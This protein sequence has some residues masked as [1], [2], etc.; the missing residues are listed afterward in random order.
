MYKKFLGGYNMKKAKVFLCLALVLCMVVSIAPFG[1]LAAN[2]PV[3]FVDIENWAADH[4]GKSHWA[5]RWINYWANQPSKDGNGYVIGGYYDGTFRPDDFITRGAVAAILD[6]V[7]GLDRTGAVK[8]FS[9]VPT[10]HVFYNSI[11]ECADNNVVK[12]Y[13][14][15]ENTFR[16]ANNI[17][18]QAAIAMIARC[19]MTEAD[20]AEFA[21]KTADRAYFASLWSDYKD[22]PEIYYAEF[23]FLAKYGN[24]EGYLD[25]T[26]QPGRLISR[27]EFVKLLYAS[28]HED[29][30]VYKL[31]V[32][33][34]DNLRHEVS[35]TTLYLTAESNVLETL[36]PMI[37]ANRDNFKATFPSSNMCAI[38][39]EGVAIA[40]NGYTNNWEGSYLTAWQD[41]V[42]THYSNVG[43]EN[44][45][46]DLFANVESTIGDMTPSKSYVMT[47]WDTI[48]G[49]TDIMYTVTI[50]AEVMV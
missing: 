44:S 25:G 14:D 20:Y 40:K 23:G 7:H 32:T 24:L 37:S 49:R 41:Y 47:F 27:A 48:D 28:A 6:R 22:I 4:E 9:D 36:V 42:N 45:A 2:Q 12:G 16:P 3:Q 33:I 34:S 43:G 50:T 31:N 21:N 26:V 39:D 29:P 46:K 18:R 38:M 15:A 11:M 10:S 8:D 19:V 1:A 30:N 35:D 17:A 5:T 13:G